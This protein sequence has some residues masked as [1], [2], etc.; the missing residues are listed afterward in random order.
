MD[1][2]SCDVVLRER[3]WEAIRSRISYRL[4]LNCW[5]FLRGFVRAKGLA[6]L[7]TQEPLRGQIRRKVAHAFVVFRDA[8][9]IALA[10][11]GDPVFRAFE[12]GLEAL[13]VLIRFQ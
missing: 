11:D 2:I 13:K 6:N 7:K 12:L 10:R 3:D 8:L 5:R 4:E 9:D 1:A